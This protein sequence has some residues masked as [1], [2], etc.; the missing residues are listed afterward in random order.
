V[1]SDVDITGSEKVKRKGTFPAFG[2]PVI[3]PEMP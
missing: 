2:T 3:V 1:S